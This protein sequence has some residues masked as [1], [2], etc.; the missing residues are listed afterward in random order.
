MIKINTRRRNYVINPRLQYMVAGGFVI[1]AIFNLLFFVLAFTAMQNKAA[2]EVKSLDPAT[3]EVVLSYVQNISEPLMSSVIIFSLFTLLIAFGI[4]AMLLNHIA[5]P[6]YAI[7]KQI[8]EVLVDGN[9]RLPI[10]L[11]KHDFF[12]E[13]ADSVNK[14]LAK[15]GY[16]TNTEKKKEQ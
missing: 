2:E 15:S 1:I 16:P 8:D 13:L 6:I 3:R 14:L 11:R 4:G 5:G 7:K 9:P 10:V 12:S